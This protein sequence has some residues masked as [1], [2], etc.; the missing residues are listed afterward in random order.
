MFIALARYGQ[1]V[2]HA[3]DD[4]LT[5]TLRF[6]GHWTRLGQLQCVEANHATRK[7]ELN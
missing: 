6:H 1:L 5:L 4:V 7:N 3:T 2:T